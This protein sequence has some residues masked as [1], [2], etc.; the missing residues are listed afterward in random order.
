M[1][2]PMIIDETICNGCGQCMPECPK[3]VIKRESKHLV[4]INEGC[5]GC[6]V[7]AVVCPEG[8]VRIGQIAPDA[9]ETWCTNPPDAESWRGCMAG[10]TE[11]LRGY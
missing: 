2:T 6:Q 1:Q 11:A 9:C 10:C 5:V 8:A 4:C 3:G 7:C